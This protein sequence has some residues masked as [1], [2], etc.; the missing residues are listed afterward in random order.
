MM[1]EQQI[2]ETAALVRETLL[3]GLALESP[4]PGSPVVIMRLPAGWH[5][6]GAGNYAGVFAHPMADGAAVKVYAPGRPG[7]EDEKDVYGMLGEHPAFSFCYYAENWNGIRYLILK[8][9]RGITLYDCLKKGIPVPVGVIEEID[10]ALDYARSKGLHPHDVHA[11]NVMMQDGSG[12]VVDISD[13]LK[14]EDCT[15]WDD[16]KKAYRRFYLPFLSKHPKPMPEWVLNGVRKGY[17]LYR[18]LSGV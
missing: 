4:A 14:R 18:E 12:L 17:R 7:W 2:R 15:M 9:L 13:F 5:V 8:R 10:R 3:R 16:L 1:T 6:L 11:K